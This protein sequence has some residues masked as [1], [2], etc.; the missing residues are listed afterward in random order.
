MGTYPADRQLGSA[1]PMATSELAEMLMVSRWCA[2]ALAQPPNGGY[3]EEQEASLHE[4]LDRNLSLLQSELDDLRTKENQ[5]QWSENNREC[6]PQCPSEAPPRHLGASRS[7][8][9]SWAGPT[10]A[11]KETNP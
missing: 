3:S 1:L 7:H 10:Q 5:R 8:V 6:I 4:A 9:P 2:K 11:R